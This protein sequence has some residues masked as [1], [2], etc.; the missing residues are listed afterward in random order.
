MT[1]KIIVLLTVLCLTPLLPAD[2]WQDLAS[3][4]LGDETKAPDELDK[5]VLEAGPAKYAPIEKKLIALVQSPDATSVAKGY[6]C[7]MLQRI[8]TPASVPALSGLLHDKVLSHY[9]RLALERMTKCPEAGAA[10]RKA[11]DGAPESVQAGIAASLGERRDAAAVGQISKLV[12]S[13]RTDVACVAMKS[14][15]KIGGKDALRALQQAKVPKALE[16]ARL[17][18]LIACAAGLTPKAEAYAALDGVYRGGGSEAQRAAA[19]TEMAKVDQAKASPIIVGLVRGKPGH[20]RGGA[21]RLVVTAKGDELTAAVVGCLAGLDAKA[22]AMVVELLGKRGDKAALPAVLKQ[23]ESKDDTVRAAAL[24]AVSELGGPAQVRVLLEQAKAGG[25]GTKALDAVARMSADGI[26][27]AL[28]SLLADGAL[29][30]E[31]VKALAARGSRSAG[32][33]VMKLAK[34]PDASVRLAAWNSMGQLATESDVDALMKLVIGIKEPSERSAAQ[35]A[36]RWICSEA[37]DR[38][39]CFD[40]IAAYHEQADDAIKLFVLELG[41]SAGTKKA[42]A[43]EA[44]AMKSGNK[45]Q[46]DKALRALA[47]WPNAGAAPELLAVAREGSDDTEKIVAL[48]GYIQ[49]AGTSGS[50]KDKAARYKAVADLAQRRDDKRLLISKLKGCRHIDSFRVAVK[51]LADDEVKAEAEI[52]AID[53]GSRIGRGR[54]LQEVS[55]TVESIA[56]TSKNKGTVRRA[57]DCLKRINPKK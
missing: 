17:E 47:G 44:A 29:R 11:L 5:L 15:G 52:A 21:L 26:D 57:N 42:L 43:L 37:N 9:A 38:D 54:N 28:V 32:P 36:I 41:P 8:G 31:A 24:A 19:L 12:A 13:P 30:A 6:A 2:V 25:A 14:L 27:A 39:K 46:R 3:Y 48:R 45:Q 53:L 51:F 20:L 16:A 49:V 1:R 35:G 7:R 55:A 50:D 22:R 10:L 34:D 4:K 23:I 18:A 56:K 40:A 33:A